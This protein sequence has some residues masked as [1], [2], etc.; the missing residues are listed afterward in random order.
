MGNMM[1]NIMGTVSL[2]PGTNPT[3]SYRKKLREPVGWVF[4]LPSLISVLFVA[5]VFHWGYS[6]I[7]SG[8]L[9]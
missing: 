5:A 1:E 3:Y 2:N 8:K 6:M 4:Y 7:P 9:T